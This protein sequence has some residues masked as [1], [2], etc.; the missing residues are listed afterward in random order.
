[1]TLPE[2]TTSVAF[3]PDARI[4][5]LGNVDN[6]IRLQDAA[7][8]KE[9]R[10]LTAPATGAVVLAFSPDST[11]LAARGNGN[12]PIRIYDVAKGTDLQQIQIQAENA[13]PNPGG[14]VVAWSGGFGNGTGLVFSPD[15][16]SLASV[17]AGVGGAAP[18][19]IVVNAPQARSQL[20]VW[21][22][23]TGKAVRKID[24]PTQRGATSLAF[25]PDG[26]V[27][28]TDH[29]DQTITLWEIASG[30]ERL[31]LGKPAAGNVRAGAT[32]I[33]VVNVGGV[34]GFG[35]AAST[36]LAF[37]PDGRTLAS[38]GPGRTVRIWDT[39]TGN[40][41]GQFKGHEGDV[42]TVAFAPDGKAVA[43]GSNDT[44]ILLWNVTHLGRGP[45]PAVVELQARDV[46]ALW[47]DLASDEGGKAFQAILKLTTAPKQT[48]L[49]LKEHL[50]PAV[51]VPQKKIEQWIADLDSEAFPTRKS[52]AEQ[53]EKIGDLAVPALKKVLAGQPAL[54]TRKRVEELLEG[55]TGTSL[56]TE[57]LRLVRAVEVLERLNSTEARQVLED[58][59]RGAPGALPTREGQTVLDRLTKR[60]GSRP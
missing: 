30:K 17:V 27:L 40:E 12:N 59:A 28:A 50:K 58:L 36:T 15:G 19:A 6:T 26:R 41:L 31:Q 53:L 47:A 1:L 4:V 56:S 51:S 20:H 57:Q 32:A 39:T 42:T 55:L 9:L 13:R 52:A 38:R 49:L 10:K 5:A 44:T 3:S 35:A 54:E 21:D 45:K 22:V 8:G 24:L 33:M 23:A 60:P 2:G 18:G 43:S 25:S 46:E 34:G 29:S 16:K 48:L 11:T 7:T 37:A 14:A